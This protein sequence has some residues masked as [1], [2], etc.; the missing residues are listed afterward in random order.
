[1]FNDDFV[2]KCYANEVLGDDFFKVMPMKRYMLGK[3]SQ[4]ES[5]EA[6]NASKN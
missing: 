6:F 3:K 4:R 2:L 1:V 5:D